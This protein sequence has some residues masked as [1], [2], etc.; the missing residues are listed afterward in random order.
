MLCGCRLAFIPMPSIF[1]IPTQ[2][3]V[4]STGYWGKATAVHQFC[5]PKYAM[6]PYV[7]EFY[8]SLSSFIYVFTACYALSK[9]AARNDPL[10]LFTG[11]SIAVIGLGSVAF[12]GTMLFEFE[13]GA[14]DS[15][16]NFLGCYEVFC[17]FSLLSCPHVPQIRAGPR[18]LCS[19]ATRCRCSSSSPLLSSTRWARI[20]C[21]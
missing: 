7:A 2:S 19:C 12:H 6:S 10:I 8:N 20:R 4:P 17:S 1:T 15:S 18:A 21:S 14:K 16:S 3:D 11:V 9:P 5:E 13:V